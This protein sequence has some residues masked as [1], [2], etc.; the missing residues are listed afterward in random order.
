MQKLES[1]NRQIQR[2]A[3]R[4]TEAFSHLN[5]LLAMRMRAMDGMHEAEEAL[6]ALDEARERASHDE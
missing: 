4:S 2:E 6:R 5:M 1:S 3:Q